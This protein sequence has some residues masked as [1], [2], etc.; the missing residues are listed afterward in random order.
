MVDRAVGTCS[1]GEAVVHLKH[2][3]DRAAVCAG[4][5]PSRVLKVAGRLMLEI[6]GQ[7]VAE[8]LMTVGMDLRVVRGQPLYRSSSRHSLRRDD[9]FFSLLSLVLDSKENLKSCVCRRVKFPHVT[10]PSDILGS[11]H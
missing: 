9:S 2:R 4:S 11:S 3:V 10:L 5:Q 6:S 8:P 7:A 1:A